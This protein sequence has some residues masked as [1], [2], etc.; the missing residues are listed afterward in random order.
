MNDLEGFS[1]LLEAVG[2]GSDGR[3][4]TSRGKGR[5]V[6][7]SPHRSSS[8]PNGTLAFELSTVVVVG[9]EARECSDLSTIEFTQFGQIGEKVMACYACDSG[10]TFDEFCFVLPIVVGLDEV[11]DGRIECGDLF[12][13]SPEKLR[14]ASAGDLRDGGIQ[15]VG[16]HRS[17]RQQLSSPCDEILEFL[18]LFWGF[19]A[20]QRLDH[21]GKS[22]QAGGVDGIG[23]GEHT[24]AAREVARLARIDDSHGDVCGRQFGNK[25]ALEA[26]RSFDND[27]DLPPRGEEFEKRLDPIVIVAERVSF[28]IREF[29]NIELVLGNIDA[30][31]SDGGNG[32]GDIHGDNPVLQMRARNR[33]TA[34][35]LAAVRAYSKRPAGILRCDG[36]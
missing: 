26:T 9:S 19:L 36:V 24:E 17:E 27:K 2:E 33:F 20:G 13:E 23:L 4:T 14:D 5:H 22:C 8:A 32:R 18:L 1:G 10:D 6:E 30:H 31:E 28:R 3:V 35:A 16:L 21:L 12:V 15:A 11:R 34:T 25:S 29:I 7:A